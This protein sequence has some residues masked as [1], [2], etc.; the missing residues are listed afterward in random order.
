MVRFASIMSMSNRAFGR[1]GL[2]AVMGS[3]NLRAIAVRG[4]GKVE[5]ADRA[6]VAALARTGS[7][8]MQAGDMVGMQKHGTDGVLGPQDRSGGLPT[9]NWQSGTFEEACAINGETMSD[10]I[11]VENDTCYACVVR[12]KRVV[13]T[14]YGGQKVIPYY[15]GPEYETVG[16][17]GSDCG[18]GNLEAVALAN[19]LCNQYGIDTISCGATIAFAMECYSRGII[20]PEDTG[21][22]EMPMGDADAMVRLV[23]MI[24]KREG[25][26]DL[27]AEGSER[28]AQRIGR[29]AEKYV[30][31]V[32][33]Q[34]NPAHMPQVKRS[35]AL[36]YGVN[37]FGADHMS[38]EH[39]PGYTMEAGTES[40]ERLA[41]LGLN[42]P[43]PSQLLDAEKVHF[44]I[45]TQWNYSF[46]DSAN[47]CQFVWGPSWQLMSSAQMAELMTAVTGVPTSIEDTQRVGERRVNLIRA[48]NA[49]EG[50]G[51]DRDTLPQRLTEPLAGGAS[52]GLFV[53]QAEFE[54]ALN[55]YYQMAGWDENGMP[56]REK[57]EQLGIGW[58]I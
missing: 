2:G 43:R 6:K 24:A 58:V 26:G 38:A 45:V 12:C 8:R 36:I 42:D 44:A 27:L 53:T 22:V 1:T 31:A 11:L 9:R 41:S 30:V 32:K 15:G 51:R 46:M 37:P 49:R 23:E 13:E 54:A 19:Q 28:A 55:T 7:K 35:L 14:E 34:E 4:H 47:L 5:V 25:I 29:G 20:T 39:D 3:K 57:L 21:G 17:L 48:F 10:T 16:M 50:A 56:T 52:D 40:L 33:G 18:V